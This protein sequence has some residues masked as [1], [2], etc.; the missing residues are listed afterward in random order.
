MILCSAARHARRLGRE[1]RTEL[2][3]W[4]RRELTSSKVEGVC[5]LRTKTNPI[6][7]LMK[8]EWCGTAM[9]RVAFDSFD[10]SQDLRFPRAG[11]TCVGLG[12]RGARQVAKYSVGQF[13]CLLG[14]SNEDNIIDLSTA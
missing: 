13:V 11:D 3:G 1:P 10:S 6:L 7:H 4:R 8:S 9:V 5:D 2:S 14:I 12:D